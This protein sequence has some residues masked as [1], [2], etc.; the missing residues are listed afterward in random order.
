MRTK[1]IITVF[2][3]FTQI[4]KVKRIAY[5]TSGGKFTYKLTFY[6]PINCICAVILV[7]ICTDIS[8]LP[9]PK[10]QV[11]RHGPQ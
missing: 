5:M 11:D 10:Q 3:L 4:K 2:K 7:I 9:E 8:R 1:R 6:L